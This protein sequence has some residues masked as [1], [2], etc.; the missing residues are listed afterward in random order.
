MQHSRSKQRKV[1]CYTKIAKQWGLNHAQ[2]LFSSLDA[3]LPFYST[4]EQM[5]G[6]LAKYAHASS[7]M[8]Y[9]VAVR[10]LREAVLFRLSRPGRHR[11][12][13]GL[14]LSDV[15]CAMGRLHSP[16][17]ALG[18]HSYLVSWILALLFKSQL[19]C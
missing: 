9:E 5:F 16:P 19:A 3:P 1:R 15:K 10:H 11:K 18:G 8:N 13:H 12:T 14:T 2:L 7:H 4:G 6:D 17:D